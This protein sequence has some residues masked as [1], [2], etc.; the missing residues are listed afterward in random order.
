MI[1]LSEPPGNLHPYVPNTPSPT[2][3]ATNVPLNTNL[4]WV[5]GD[6]N[7]GDI[8]TYDVYFDTVSP[9]TKKASNQS[10]TTYNPNSLNP[11]TKYYW[12]IVA[13]DNYGLSTVGPIW[14]FTTKTN[15]PP[16]N[17]TITGPSNG[18]IK[19]MITYNFTTTDLDANEV[20]YFIDWGDGMNSSWVGPY[21]S[22]DVITQSHTWLKKGTYTIKAKAKDN[23]GSESDWGQLSVTMP[24]SYNIPFHLFWERLFERFPNA[25]PILR[26]LMDY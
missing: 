14:E 3:G 24:F 12:K 7:A 9:P 16:N 10:A 13:W 21:P 18:R 19:V 17:P 22:G 15:T 6:P 25:F 11:T 8:V 5:G 2:N 4:S 20:H 26:H 23:Y 1:E